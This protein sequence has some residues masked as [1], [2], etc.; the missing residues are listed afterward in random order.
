MGQ[1]YYIVF[2]NEKKM[3]GK[4]HNLYAF[5]VPSIRSGS[6]LGEMAY[7]EN[8]CAMFTT[9]ALAGPLAGCSVAFTGENDNGHMVEVDGKEM[10]FYHY[11]QKFEEGCYGDVP[12]IYDEYT[13]SYQPA[14]IYINEAYY[15]HE[16]FIINHTKKEYIDMTVDYKG[17]YPFYGLVQSTTSGGDMLDIEFDYGEWAF[18]EI[19]ATNDPR[20]IVGYKQILNNIRY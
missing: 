14:A 20:K 1:F 8:P 16:R 6:K 3:K 13:D 10:N 18:D 15:T 5:I 19:S 9:R 17:I 2:L 7:L 12:S 4:N 11:V